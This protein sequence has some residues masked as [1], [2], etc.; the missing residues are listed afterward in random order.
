MFLSFGGD[1]IQRHF[2]GHTAVSKCKD[3]STFQRLIQ[4]Y[5]YRT[6]GYQVIISLL[7]KGDRVSLW[8][9]VN[10]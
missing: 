6:A 3:V 9:I 1:K 8:N 7:K 10:F 4:V 5:I 2:L